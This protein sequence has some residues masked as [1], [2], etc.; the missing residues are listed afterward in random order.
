M[1][2]RMNDLG[3]VV[4]PVQGHLP[5]IAPGRVDTYSCISG[6][7]YYFGGPAS[8]L[9]CACDI[10]SNSSL[11]LGRHPPKNGACAKT[12][13]EISRNDEL[14]VCYGDL[15]HSFPCRKCGKPSQSIQH[16]HFDHA[17]VL[18]SLSHLVNT[19]GATASVFILALHKEADELEKAIQRITM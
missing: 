7:L 4:A 18:P 19:Q 12:T 1:G 8:L 16:Q 17:P 5:S 10:H 11:C 9:N 2:Q 6:N 13:D 3:W 15:A 14:V